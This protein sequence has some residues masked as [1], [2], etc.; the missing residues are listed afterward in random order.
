MREMRGCRPR[1]DPQ[2][3]IAREADPL[4]LRPI[5]QRRIIETHPLL[6]RRRHNV[7]HGIRSRLHDRHDRAA[8]HCCNTPVP[9]GSQL[10]GAASER[11]RQG[12]RAVKCPG[13]RVQSE[14]DNDEQHSD[15]RWRSNEVRHAGM[16]T[17]AFPKRLPGRL[18]ALPDAPTPNFA[19][20]VY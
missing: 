4:S 12:E 15:A 2:L 8:S 17:A 7:G 9:G 19:L 13:R 16:R 20:E 14:T 5:S 6:C 18:T 10:H 3:V 11:A 1:S